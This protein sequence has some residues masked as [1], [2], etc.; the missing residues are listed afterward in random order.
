VSW[1]QFQIAPDLCCEGFSAKKIAL[2]GRSLF[3]AHLPFVEPRGV[4]QPLSWDCIARLKFSHVC[5][6]EERPFCLHN[7]CCFR[8]VAPRFKA[9]PV[10]RSRPRWPRGF[11]SDN[12]SFGL[13][14]VPRYVRHVK[15]LCR[16]VAAVSVAICP[17]GRRLSSMFIGT[18]VVLRVS[19][20]I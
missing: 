3:C 19:S 20:C 4:V 17:L 7:R 11:Y 2:H 10:Y 5:N 1:L 8:F 18:M 16:I 9:V 12:R 14:N 15:Q 13:C 6:I